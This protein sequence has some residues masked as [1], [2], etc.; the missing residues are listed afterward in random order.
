MIELPFTPP[1]ASTVAGTVDLLTFALVG[2]GGF[3]SSIVLV[4]IVVFAIRYRR[5]AV[6]DRSD[7]PITSIKVEL[8]W[9][10]LLLFL[11]MGM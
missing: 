4:L 10:F 1:Q 11:A 9:V 5:T 8:S 6:I 3:F 2:L 7:P